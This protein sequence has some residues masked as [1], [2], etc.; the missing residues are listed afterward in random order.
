MIV[1]RANMEG[2]VA[3]RLMT[4]EILE[5]NMLSFAAKLSFVR[6]IKRCRSENPS[7]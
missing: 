1:L 5:G 4:R 2:R 7:A 3:K 6:C